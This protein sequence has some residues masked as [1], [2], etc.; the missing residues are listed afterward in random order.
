[1]PLAQVQLTMTVAYDVDQVTDDIKLKI[2]QAV[3]AHLNV[4]LWVVVLRV[5]SGSVQLEISVDFAQAELAASTA[6]L[7]AEVA[8]EPEAAEAF[9]AAAGVPHQSH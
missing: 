9:F 5:V 4:P 2:R 6:G 3:A 7:L 8:S 1:M